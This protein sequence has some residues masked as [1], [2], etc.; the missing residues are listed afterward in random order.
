MHTLH[1]IIK[2]QTRIMFHS[3]SL[4]HGANEINGEKM[5][6]IN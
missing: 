1:D 6:L 3:F 4:F 2:Y 5:V